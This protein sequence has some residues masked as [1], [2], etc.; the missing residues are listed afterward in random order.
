MNP[1]DWELLDKQL[2]GFSSRPP[3]K[4]GAVGLVS[5]QC[6]WPVWPSGES[7]LVTTASSNNSRR[8]RR[9]LR[10]PFSML[11]RQLCGNLYSR[12]EQSEQK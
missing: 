6:S 2:Y 1:H 9:G 5:S 12:H 4:G 3:Q 10:F 11:C 8:K 7:C